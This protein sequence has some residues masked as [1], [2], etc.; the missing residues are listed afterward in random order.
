MNFI[1]DKEYD[2]NGLPIIFYNMNYD[3][4]NPYPVVGCINF[5]GYKYITSWTIDGKNS[6][7]TAYDLNI[8]FDFSTKKEKSKIKP[9]YGIF[10]KH[11]KT[12]LIHPIEYKL[13]DD[14]GLAEDYLKEFEESYKFYYGDNY[15]ILELNQE[16]EW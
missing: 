1:L 13:F 12:G 7:S 8:I 6:D 2:I 14:Y 10:Y 11:V 4:N 5:P 16:V 15:K 3:E 9:I